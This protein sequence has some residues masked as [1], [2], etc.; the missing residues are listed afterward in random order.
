MTAQ[1]FSAP[2]KIVL[3]GEYAVLRGAPAVAMAVDRRAVVTVEQG[4]AQVRCIG[5]DGKTDTRLVDCVLDELS[6]ERPNVHLTLDTAAFSDGPDK[7]GIGSSAALAVALARALAPEDVDASEQL[8]V[9]RHAHRAFQQGRGSGVDVAAS[10]AGGIIVYRMQDAATQSIAW[11]AALHSALFWTG[12]SVSTK[13]RV[14]RFDASAEHP[15]TNVLCDAAEKLAGAWRRGRAEDVLSVYVPYLDALK[16][17]DS[18]HGLGIFDGGHAELAIAES[19]FVYK[20]CGAGGGDVGI[21]LSSDADRLREFAK[22]A[23]EQG[24][25]QLDISLDPRGVGE[26]STDG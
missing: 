23:G 6:R 17:F 7:L 19:G 14:A 1:A 13:E 24:I 4:G 8:N 18:A 21:A 25:R 11:P 3:S 2:G 20:P 16:N 15:A 10:S 12:T 22:R 26:D 5:L 9:A